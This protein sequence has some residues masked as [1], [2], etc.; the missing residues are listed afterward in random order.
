[1]AGETL[2]IISKEQLAELDLVISKLERIK[3]LTEEINCKLFNKKEG[4]ERP[5]FPE[6]N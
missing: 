4:Y 2:E 3:Q 1:M 5:E 6:R